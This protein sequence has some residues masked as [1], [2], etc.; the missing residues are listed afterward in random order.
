M[1]H[2]LRQLGSLKA[3]K[4]SSYPF[5]KRLDPANEPPF[6]PGCSGSSLS[7][8]FTS[9]LGLRAREPPWFHSSKLD[10][11]SCCDLSAK[12]NHNTAGL[13]APLQEI[14]NA[15]LCRRILSSDHFV[16][17]QSKWHSMWKWV[18]DKK[19]R[20]TIVLTSV[21]SKEEKLRPYKGV[22][23]YILSYWLSNGHP[24]SFMFLKIRREHLQ[25]FK[26]A[27]FW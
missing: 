22:S 8:P 14:N 13:L 16:T 3:G 2:L 15:S 24:E 7:W 1:L 17:F 5:R 11:T 20:S 4:F 23:N 25:N 18:T 6:M 21:Q 19:H 12:C 27:N 26:L 9:P 10:V